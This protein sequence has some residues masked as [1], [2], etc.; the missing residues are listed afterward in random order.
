VRVGELVDEAR[1]A[2]PRLADD[3]HHLTV[4]VARELLRAAELLQLGVAAD[5]PRQPTPGGRLQTGPRRARPRHLVDLHRFREP[6]HRHGAKR[7]HRD[8]ALGQSQRPGRDHDRTGIGDLLH[9]RGQVRRLADRGV[10]H[11]QI[12]S[13]G[14][15]DDLTG[16]ES[17]SDLNV[18]AVSVARVISVSLHRLLHPQRRIARPHGVIL[19]RERRAKQRHDPIAHHLVHRALVAVNGLHHAF[20]HGVKEFTGL[21]GIAVGEQL[22][23][24]L[25][26]GEEDRDLLAL[27]FQGRLGRQDL[28][29]EVLGGVGLRRVEPRGDARSGSRDS[30]TALPAELGAGT[31]RFAAPRADSFEA[32]AAFVAESSVSGVLV[33]A[34]RTPHPGLQYSLLRRSMIP[35]MV[36]DRRPQPHTLSWTPAGSMIDLGTLGGGAT[37]AYAVNAAAR[38]SA[39]AAPLTMRRAMRCCGRPAVRSRSD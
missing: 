28:L 27:A 18:H 38:S 32:G 30:L 19:V 26:I 3:R 37:Q 35:T 6:L 8:V 29:G 22:H 9:P 13:D 15:H 36:A 33:L 16:V 7:F 5:K 25:Q 23:R 17:D 2:H 31:I 11:V 14:T 24:A 10:V 1:L 20:Q 4:T 21:L 39:T 12:A 34:P